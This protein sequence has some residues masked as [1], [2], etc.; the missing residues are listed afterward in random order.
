MATKKPFPFGKETK[1]EERAE[2]RMP[3]A[4]YAAM[5]KREA[6]STSKPTKRG[7]SRGR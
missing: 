2:K 5:E 7:A 1:R 4:A 3:P 6:K